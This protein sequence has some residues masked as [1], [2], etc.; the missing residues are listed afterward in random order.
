[1]TCPTACTL[2]CVIPSLIPA[3]NIAAGCPAGL[4]A[5][6]RR[7]SCREIA[8]KFPNHAIVIVD[9]PIPDVHLN[10]KRNRNLLT[11][12]TLSCHKVCL[13]AGQ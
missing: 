13:K 11:G 12:R 8:T 1:M 7:C 9:S 6:Y 3:L 2:S 10:F 4:P 5:K